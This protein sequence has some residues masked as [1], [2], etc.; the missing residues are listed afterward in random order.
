[1]LRGARRSDRP[2]SRVQTFIK[3]TAEIAKASKLRVGQ[4][5]SILQGT[6]KDSGKY[7]IIAD[8]NGSYKLG[9][10]TGAY[11]LQVRTQRL[12]RNSRV[13]TQATVTSYGKGVVTIAI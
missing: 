6:G 3:L 4:R 9:R 10:A 5:V 8:A 13:S 2:N 7:R 11:R 12:L 1:M